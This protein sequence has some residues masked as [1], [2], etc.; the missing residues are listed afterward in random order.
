VKVQLCFLVATSCT[1]IAL[2]E[3]KADSVLTIKPTGTL[4]TTPQITPLADTA[5]TMDLNKLIRVQRAPECARYVSA[6]PIAVVELSVATPQLNLALRGARGILV[7]PEHEFTFWS[8]CRPAGQEWAKIA[9][10]DKGWPAGRYEVYATSIQPNDHAQHVAIALSDPNNITPQEAAAA[11]KLVDDDKAARSKPHFV[12]V[13]DRFKELTSADSI[14]L[15][16]LDEVIGKSTA[17]MWYS[18]GDCPHDAYYAPVPDQSGQDPDMIGV[19]DQI[20][21]SAHPYA[22]VWTATGELRLGVRTQNLAPGTPVLVWEENVEKGEL[23]LVTADG[24][25]YRMFGR[26]T[27]AGPQFSCGSPMLVAGIHAPL[28]APFQ[29]VVLSSKQILALEQLGFMPVGLAKKIETARAAGSA[30]TDALWKHKFEARDNANVVANITAQTR[31]NR[32]Q[33]I[34]ADYTASFGSCASAKKAF[35][36]AFEKAID[37]NKKRRLDAYQSVSA[38]LEELAR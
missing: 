15:D 29:A 21:T 37:A 34:L 36:T 7:K 14:N 33:Q 8:S 6:K 5:I 24:G 26:P 19:E 22:E 18:L 10:T 17:D 25:R 11:Q 23:T 9:T 12:L 3:S 31:A 13:M 1:L 38:K 16:K 35:D 20:G 32:R 4:S 28:P 30:C 2:R 27:S